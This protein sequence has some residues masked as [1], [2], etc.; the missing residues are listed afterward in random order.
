MLQLV[1]LPADADVPTLAGRAS[2]DEPGV[3]AARASGSVQPGC[4]LFLGRLNEK[5]GVFD[6]LRAW[7]AVRALVPE[8]RLVLAGN[9]DVRPLLELASQLGVRETLVLP[10]WITGA[11]KREW[12]A[13][14][15]IF[16]LP[17]HAEGLPVSV[18]E[19]MICGIPVV[20]TDVGGIPEV[21]ADGAEGVLVPQS[22]PRALANALSGLLQDGTRR[23]S[24]A[25]AALARA[26]RDFAAAPVLAALEEVWRETATGYEPS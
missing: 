18:L 21:V 23:E 9:G 2:T 4:V 15:D 13:R 12:L 3:R 14:A 25:T 7:P 19:A 26:K 20:A 17:S 22:D 5:K 10:G 24:V 8:A 16:V 6:L 1:A 11:G